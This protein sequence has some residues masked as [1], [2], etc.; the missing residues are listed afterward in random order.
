MF[1]HAFPS[2]TDAVFSVRT[3]L[4][5]ESA[6]G[7]MDTTLSAALPSVILASVNNS[8]ADEI[9]VGVVKAQLSVHRVGRDVHVPLGRCLDVGATPGQDRVL[10]A[11]A[12]YGIFKQAVVVVDAGT[13][14]TVDYVD[15]DG[16]YHG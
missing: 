6:K 15:D 2:P 4:C 1:L 13:A 11:A 10:A 9:E 7:A 12:A 14:V 16:V 5:E 8:V 3:Q